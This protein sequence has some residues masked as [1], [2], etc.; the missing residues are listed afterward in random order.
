MAHQNEVFE[1]DAIRKHIKGEVTAGNI[2][3]GPSLQAPLKRIKRK[4]QPVRFSKPEVRARGILN[5]KADL[6]AIL[7]KDPATWT[8]GHHKIIHIIENA[9]NLLHNE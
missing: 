6:L 1:L 5:L 2:P 7:P 8:D 9:H 4:L 3:N